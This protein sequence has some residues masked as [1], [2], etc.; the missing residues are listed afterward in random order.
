MGESTDE[1][2]NFFQGRDFTGAG[3]LPELLELAERT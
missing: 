3:H 1:E 2:T